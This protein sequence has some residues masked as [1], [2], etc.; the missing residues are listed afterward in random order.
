MET[1]ENNNGIKEA[2]EVRVLFVATLLRDHIKKFHIPYLKM[3]KEHGWSVEVAAGNDSGKTDVSIPYCDAYHDIRFGRLPWQKSNISA[4]KKLKKLIEEN[5]YD[6]IH[7]HVHISAAL[8]R[9]AARKAR[10]RGTKVI[11]TTHGFYFFKKSPLRNW[12]FYPLEKYYGS[13]TDAIITVNHGDYEQVKKFKAGKKYLI[14]GIGVNKERLTASKEQKTENRKRVREELGIP[15]ESIVILSV[16]DLSPC[17]NHMIVLKAMPLLA[18]AG[19][20]YII[21]GDG[22]TEDELRREVKASG[23]EER[24]HF[25]GFKEDILPYYNAADIFVFPSNREGLGIAAL[26]AMTCGLP[27]VTSNVGG[28]MEYAEDG[29]TGIV[30]NSTKDAAAYALAIDKLAK[31]PDKRRRI[32]KYN[33]R[34]AEPYLLEHVLPLMEEIYRETAGRL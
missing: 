14:P 15:P 23:L 18:T 20:H 16:G 6:I 3:F 1:A 11:Y 32:G 30:V 26:E 5:N 7:C 25:T 24:V 8:T 2:E 12:I 27:M 29:K 19:I 9:M 34:A 22:T 28:I 17:K 33:I 21:C 31:D 13:M 10:K 4:Y